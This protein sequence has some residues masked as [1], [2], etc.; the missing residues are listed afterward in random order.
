[1]NKYSFAGSTFKQRNVMPGDVPQNGSI[2]KG[3]IS[4]K[5]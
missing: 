3:W 1:M 4:R 5:W 2:P